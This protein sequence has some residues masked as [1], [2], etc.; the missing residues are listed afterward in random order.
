MDFELRQNLINTRRTI[1]GLLTDIDNIIRTTDRF[2]RNLNNYNPYYIFTW[3]K[4][5]NLYEDLESVK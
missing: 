5:Y 4:I 2:N 1:E 3:I